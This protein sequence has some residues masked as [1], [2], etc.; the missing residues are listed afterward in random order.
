MRED[1]EKK[2]SLGDLASVQANLLDKL[3]ELMGNLEG[4]F[5]DKDATRKKLA[6]LEKA[7]SHILTAVKISF[8]LKVKQLH[9]MVKI[10]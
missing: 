8:L 4:M 10:L 3:N 7:V 9:E 2:V 5:A 6:A 1:L